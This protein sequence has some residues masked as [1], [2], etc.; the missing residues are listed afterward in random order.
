MGF[1]PSV[2]PYCS[3][4]CGILLETRGGR[5]IGTHPDVRHSSSKGSLCMRGW[6]AVA[7][8]THHDRLTVPLLREKDQLVPVSA[9]KALKAI[10]QG[11]DSLRAKKGSS[12]LFCLGP[13]C[14]NEDAYAIKKLAFE[15]KAR[16]CPTDLVGFPAARHAIRKV[17]G[18]GY[19][20]GGLD[21]VANADVV[22]VFGADP[23]I[24]PQVASRLFAARQQ[25]AAVVQFD[26]FTAAVNGSRRTPVAIP[27]EHFGLLPLLLQKA[28]IDADR[29]PAAVKAAP[30]FTTF[31]DFW[32]PGKA[33]ALPEHPWLPDSKLKELVAAFLKAKNPAVIIG[34]RFLSAAGAGE[35]TV[36]LVQALVLLGAGERIV[37]MT[38][39]ANSWGT[40]DI[41]GPEKEDTDALLDLLDPA[42][43]RTFDAVVV[44]GDDLMRRT[45]KKS[46]LAE[47]LAKAG[48]VVV[49]DRFHS[50]METCAHVV[51]PSVTFAERDGTATSMF[52][53]VQRWQAAVK[54]LGESIA[55]RDWIA[56][57][58]QQLGV[59]DWPGTEAEWFAAMRKA[60]S[61][62]KTK[63]LDRLY[64]GAHGTGAHGTGAHG[65]ETH[66]AEA[67]LE[68]S[69]TLAFSPPKRT[70]VGKISKEFPLQWCFGSHPALWSTGLISEREEILRREVNQSSLHLSSADLATF[71]L[72]AGSPVK[73]ITEQAE[74]TMTVQE[75]QSLPAGV[76]LAI[77]LPGSNARALRGFFPEADCQTVGIQPI[78][79]RLEKI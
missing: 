7:A 63:A 60:T 40:W 70:T 46:K 56:H 64:T 39:E 1:T 16:A 10:G 45:A 26:L 3:C 49:I 2:C 15:L 52:G 20:P 24:C 42:G 30:S 51:L 9:K 21:S 61:S 35:A 72:R 6:N 79:V 58:G 47:R 12:V 37:L 14:T 77:P 48:L 75:D 65:A 32:R 44:V 28:G 17:F 67:V 73:V 34:D 66:G 27:P 54:P 4:G 38:G 33:P 71:G 69:T 18:R 68:E 5:L 76:L 59:K 13:T 57:I 8:P 41:L 74:A 43:T 78:P 62:Y 23:K 36:Q 31:A 25:G 55:E 22:W 53:V 50:E 19:L 11:M 29:I